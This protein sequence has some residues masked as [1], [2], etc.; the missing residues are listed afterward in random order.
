V[1]T[2]CFSFCL[3]WK[4]FIAPSILYDSFAGY[5]VLGLKLFSFSARKISPQALLAFNVSVEKSA[6]ILMGLPLYVICFFYYALQYSSLGLCTCCFTDN[7]LCGS[8]ILLGLFGVL[9]ASC[10]CMEIDFS[11]FGKFSVIF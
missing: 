3:P 11:R 4:T 7:M 10:I 2:Y 6:V 9:E 5:S 1:V 8:S